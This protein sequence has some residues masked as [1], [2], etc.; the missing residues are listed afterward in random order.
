VRSRLARAGKDATQP[1]AGFVHRGVG[2]IDDAD[3]EHEAVI[4]TVV[5][6]QCGAYAGGP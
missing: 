3:P 5:P 4:D 1:L 6:S 2:F